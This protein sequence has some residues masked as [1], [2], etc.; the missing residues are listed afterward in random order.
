[1]RHTI[2][3]LIVLVIIAGCGSRD[4][5]FVESIYDFPVWRGLNAD[6]IFAHEAIQPEAIP[7]VLTEVWK[8]SVGAGFSSMVTRGDVLYTMG[9]DKKN[10]T[11]YCINMKTGKTI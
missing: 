7:A 11:V 9:N 6:G 10:D 4:Q 3:I 1:M 5:L 8:T 2:L